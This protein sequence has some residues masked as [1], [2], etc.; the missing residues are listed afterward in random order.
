MN[1]SVCVWLSDGI[2]DWM[3]EYLQILLFFSNLSV[4]LCSSP[5]V[6][7]GDTPSSGMTLSVGSHYKSFWRLNNTF[8]LLTTDGTNA[9]IF[10]LAHCSQKGALFCLCVWFTSRSA[11]LFISLLLEKNSNDLCF[12]FHKKTCCFSLYLFALWTQSVPPC[13]V[14]HPVPW[15]LQHATHTVTAPL[16]HMDHFTLWKPFGQ[17]ELKRYKKGGEQVMSK[18]P[19]LSSISAYK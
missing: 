2:D 5:A 9:I 4:C 6:S 12:S 17:Q 18:L 11:T 16:P 13:P 15:A 7:G 19:I 14:C 8:M 3:N 1:W 10:L